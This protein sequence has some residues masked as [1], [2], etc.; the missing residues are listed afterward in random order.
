MAGLEN[1]DNAAKNNWRN[2]QW[3]QIISHFPE[4]QK[5]PHFARKPN[6]GYAA[7]IAEKKSVAYLVGPADIDREIATKKGFASHR[8]IAIDSDGECVKSARH[9]GATAIRCTLEGF[10]S[11]YDRP[12]DVVVADLCHGFTGDE[13][14][15][16]H[17][18]AS[19]KAIGKDCVIAINMLRGRDSSSNEFRAA[20][21]D[22]RTAIQ[23]QRIAEVLKESG[24]NRALH[25]YALLLEFFSVAGRGYVSDGRMM[26][27]VYSYKSGTQVFDSLVFSW[28][29]GSRSQEADELAAIH[30]LC[31][32]YSKQGDVPMIPR[33]RQLGV[34]AANPPRKSVGLSRKIAALKAVQTRKRQS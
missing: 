33:K 9:N 29:L 10:L 27:S 15:L 5:L 17:V 30:A 7:S 6:S 16:P 14:R 20:V 21:N 1:Y 19:S 12:V 3:N 23:D 2:W 22:G 34:V 11:H 24:T 31:N 25:F 18:L 32:K 28:P 8:L 4:V 13:F 26:P